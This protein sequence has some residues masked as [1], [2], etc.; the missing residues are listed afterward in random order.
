MAWREMGV[1]FL[2]LGIQSFDEGELNFLHRRHDTR[3]ARKSLVVALD[4]GFETV[5]VDLIFGLPDQSSVTWK[6]NLAEAGQSGATHVS[7]YQLTIHENTVFDRWKSAGRIVELPEDAQADLFR[8]AHRTLETSGLLAYE[9]SNFARGIEHRSR[10]NI[11]YWQ[12]TPY[13]GIG[14]S[15]HS[16]DGRRRHWNHARLETWQDYVEQGRSPVA[17]SE[18]LSLRDLALEWIML[19]LRTADGLDLLDLKATYETD[20]LSSNRER[21]HQ[22]QDQGLLLLEDN[23]LIP[24]S[25]GLAVA[26]RFARELEIQAGIDS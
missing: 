23:R 14:P 6:S 2:S 1:R 15:A 8:T 10:H 22:W 21:I 11:K 5:S 16:F 3:T 12:H 19:S 13:V 7:C 25:A 26:D 24:T 4:A 20:L 18:D 9:V 17:E